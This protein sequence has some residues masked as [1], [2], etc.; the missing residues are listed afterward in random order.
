M[1]S[2]IFQNFSYPRVSNHRQIDLIYLVFGFIQHA[3][4]SRRNFLLHNLSNVCFFF[5]A[6]TSSPLVRFTKLLFQRFL[7][8]SLILKRCLRYFFRASISTIF[9]SFLGYVPLGGFHF[10]SSISRVDFYTI[11]DPLPILC[12][13][14]KNIPLSTDYLRILSCF[15]LFV[16]R[17][18]KN[19]LENTCEQGKIKIDEK[20]VKKIDKKKMNI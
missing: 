16:V 10:L 5:T 14:E 3:A 18:V 7:F 4:K 13:F 19:F 20:F 2:D 17:F 1:E 11:I 9:L 6:N 8:S 15:Y 12:K